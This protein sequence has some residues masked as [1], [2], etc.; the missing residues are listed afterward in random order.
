MAAGRMSRKRCALFSGHVVVSRP[1]YK[2]I[3]VSAPAPD[4][5]SAT[6]RITDEIRLC[7]RV[8]RGPPAL[9]VGAHGREPALVCPPVRDGGGRVFQPARRNGQSAAAQA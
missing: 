1:T 2:K 4:V 6:I 3:N 7:R 8:V 9:T 5:P